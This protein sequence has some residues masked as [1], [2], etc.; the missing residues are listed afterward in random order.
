[1]DSGK[2]S[3]VRHYRWHILVIVAA[4]AMVISLG[5][6]TRFFEDTAAVRDGVFMFGSL[7]F[8]I[9]LMIMLAQVSGIVNTLR[10][11]SA[12]M[13]E[14]AKSL[15]LRYELENVTDLNRI[16]SFGVMMTP[17]LVVDG[18]VKL[19]GKVPSLD[20]A[21]R[22]LARSAGRRSRAAA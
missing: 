18:A 2:D 12:K 14:A 9:A 15:G 4:L 6:F 5:L 3:Q 7:V 19:A 21:K 20:E 11:N 1:M 10:D 22:L 13:E 8:I 17:A 16:M